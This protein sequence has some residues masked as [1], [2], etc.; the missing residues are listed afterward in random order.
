M[1]LVNTKQKDIQREWHI[2]DVSGKIIGRE[3]TIIS[4]LLRG[5]AKPYF[6]S[7]LDC[8]DHVIVINAIKVSATGKKEVQ[9]LYTRYSGY[10]SGLRTET[11]GQL[12][13]RKPEDI[14]RIAVSGMLP[15]NKLRDRWLK[16]LHIY[17]ED[18]H[19][20]VDKIKSK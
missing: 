6:V 11:L 7:H 17:A 3:A 1:K 19:P 13:K 8:G 10:P 15:K 12:R 5:K 2:V 9:K 20:Y 4:N 14:I 16:R 18:T